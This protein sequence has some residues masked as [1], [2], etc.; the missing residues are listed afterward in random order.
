[1]YVDVGL[2]ATQS[3]VLSAVTSG[4]AFSRSFSVKV[5]QIECTSLSRGNQLTNQSLLRLT[6]KRDWETHLFS[7]WWLFAILH[8]CQ[9]PDL[10]LQLQQ[11]CRP[12]VEQHWLQ[13]LCAHGE[14]L[15]RHPVL[16]MHWQ[17]WVYKWVDEITVWKW[18]FLLA[19]TPAMS[20]SVTGGNPA[21]GSV[22]GSVACTTDWISIPCATNTND[23][24]AQT[25]GNSWEI[26]ST[27]LLIA[28]IGTPTTCV[29]RICGMVFNS[30]TTAAGSASVPV[31]SE[32]I[33]QLKLS[34]LAA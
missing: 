19:N 5:T 4:D 13:C 33:L 22:V 15:L 18:F 14:E 3:A 21:L 32:M 16:S 26:W 10:E 31:N 9:W 27:V 8:W 28:I 25:G 7:F 29:D 20:F 12:A 11:C 30:V 6:K 17:W 2:S 34:I 1:V 23:P 24:N